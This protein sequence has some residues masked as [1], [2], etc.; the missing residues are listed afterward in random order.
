MSAWPQH[1]RLKSRRE[2]RAFL[3]MTNNE[4]HRQIIKKA[5]S[6]G[7][8]TEQVVRQCHS[9]NNIYFGQGCSMKQNPYAGQ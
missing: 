8:T 3:K 9:D 6:T 1:D 5:E 4:K 2:I 7:V